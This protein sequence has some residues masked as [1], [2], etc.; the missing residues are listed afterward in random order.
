VAITLS[1][2]PNVYY[3]AVQYLVDEGFTGAAYLDYLRILFDRLRVE[4][5]DFDGTGELGTVLLRVATKIAHAL[6]GPFATMAVMNTLPALCGFVQVGQVADALAK[7]LEYV[8]LRAQSDL[9]INVAV[10]DP[11]SGA[12]R[13]ILVVPLVLVEAVDLRYPLTRL[14]QIMKL[15]PSASLPSP[16]GERTFDV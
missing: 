5:P 16:Q 1:S 7:V 12:D 2:Q 13:E 4:K 15:G 10:R 11:W 6:D 8:H 14:K 9:S 3:R